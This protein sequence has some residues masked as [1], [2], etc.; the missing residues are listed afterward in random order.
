M[1][2]ISELQ[3][4]EM[5]RQLRRT[6]SI[7]LAY[8]ILAQLAQQPGSASDKLIQALFFNPDLG[9]ES[10]IDGIR[11][12]MRTLELCYGGVPRRQKMHEPAK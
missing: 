12:C 5:I 3:T 9:D 1:E 6:D 8:E 4:S 7:E 10:P 2:S 11:R